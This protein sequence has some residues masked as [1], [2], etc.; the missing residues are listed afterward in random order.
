MGGPGTTGQ[1]WQLAERFTSFC[2]YLRFSIQ[3]CFLLS[4]VGVLKKSYWQPWIWHVSLAT[5][6]VSVLGVFFYKQGNHL[7]IY[8]SRGD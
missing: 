5:V 6:L 4:L 7:P 8:Y 2:V 1:V 3:I